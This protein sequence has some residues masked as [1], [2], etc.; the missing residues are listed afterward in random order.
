M[1][2]IVLLGLGFTVVSCRGP[3][4]SRISEAQKRTVDVVF[5][6]DLNQ[7]V[8][9]ASS[10]GKPPQMAVWIANPDDQSIR[11]VMVTYH[12]GACD[13]GG[14]VERAVA[15]PYWVSYYNRQTGTSGPPT[16]EHPAPDAVTYATPKTHLTV[17]T[18]V[19]EGSCWNYFIEVN[20]SGDFNADFPKQPK[21]GHTD[22]DGNGQPSLVYGGSIE[23]VRE[24]VSQPTVLG[25]TDQYEPTSKLTEGTGGL[26][27]ALELLK[28]MKVFCR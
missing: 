15:L 1:Q 24:A 13:W 8:Y 19:P 7:E 10:Y 4:V 14:Q 27:T 9:Q 20:V 22:R 2:L 3:S 21:N 11:T 23:A 12:A 5:E 28:S 25:H 6:I 17:V 16:K 26:T 18:R